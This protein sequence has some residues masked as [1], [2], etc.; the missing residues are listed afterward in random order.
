MPATSAFAKR[1]DRRRA[2]ERAAALLER[3]GPALPLYLRFFRADNATAG[4][5]AK[6]VEWFDE[7]D[8]PRTMTRYGVSSALV[9]G[10]DPSR[11][12]RIIGDPPAEFAHFRST[13]PVGSGAM[14]EN[15]GAPSHSGTVP[16]SS[17]VARLA[18]REPRDALPR[19]TPLPRRARLR[20]EAQ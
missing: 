1:R 4:K 19:L 18:R 6:G 15:I 7:A 13:S 14:L 8:P 11:D 3:L 16:R 9:V 5:S 12:A 10:P 17:T 20:H 2:Q